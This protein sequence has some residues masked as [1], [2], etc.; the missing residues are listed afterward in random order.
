MATV[1]NFNTSYT[2]QGPAVTITG[3]LTVLGNTTTVTSN[4][5]ALTDNILILNN[6]ETAGG[7][8]KGNAGI[9][10]NRGSLIA[11][12]LLWNQLAGNVWQITDNDGNFGNIITSP[13]TSNLSSSIFAISGDPDVIFSS[14]L[15]LL[16]AETAPTVAFD[17]STLVYAAPAG[18]GTSGLYVLNGAAANE[19]LVTKRRAFGFSLIL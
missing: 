5:I 8:T 19:E 13:L 4:N 10:I 17:N 12:Q 15:R 18:G 7:V 11:A 16:N 6:G 14:N 2:L 1:K 9:L 3:N